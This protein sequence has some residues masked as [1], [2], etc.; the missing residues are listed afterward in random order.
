V[1][2]ARHSVWPA[3]CLRCTNN[4]LSPRAAVPPAAGLPR[5]QHS[6]G[7]REGAGGGQLPVIWVS[8]HWGLPVRA[9]AGV[10]VGPVAG[11]A[12][13]HGRMAAAGSSS[14]GS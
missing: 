5:L 2:G 4:N 7:G 8:S 3:A 10:G 11:T 1:V 6:P 14:K 13:G 12:G 9:V